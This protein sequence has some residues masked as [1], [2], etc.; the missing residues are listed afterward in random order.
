VSEPAPPTP[1]RR[2]RFQ[3]IRLGGTLRSSALL[4]YGIIVGAMVGLATYMHVFDGQE[5]TS[6]Y[7][8]GPAIGAVWFALRL[9]MMLNSRK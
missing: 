9:F 8:V 5:L 6:P 4:V 1:P 2:T 7:V 3:P